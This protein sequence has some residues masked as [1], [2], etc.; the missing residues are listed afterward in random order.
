MVEVREKSR[1][2]A[3]IM[4]ALEGVKRREIPQWI[5]LDA[6]G[7]KGRVRDLPTRDDVTAP[8][9]E[10]LVVELYSK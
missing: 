1:N 6:A 5:E 10:R 7:M 8:M 4:G 2:T 9:N 3:R